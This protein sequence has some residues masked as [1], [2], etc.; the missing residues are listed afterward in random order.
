[1][2]KLHGIKQSWIWKQDGTIYKATLHSNVFT[3]KTG[4]IHRFIGDSVIL[5]I[6]GLTLESQNSIIK[7]MNKTRLSLESDE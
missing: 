5:K 1:M 3:I 6:R 2:N 7:Y 4:N